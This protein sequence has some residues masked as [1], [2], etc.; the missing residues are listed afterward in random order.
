MIINIIR[1]SRCEEFSFMVGQESGACGA[2]A[3]F[4]V[5]G[6]VTLL[7]RVSPALQPNSGNCGCG[8][9]GYALAENVKC[10]G[11][12]ASIKKAVFLGALC[13]LARA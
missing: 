1:M 6:G 3:G 2:A 13:V 7:V 11:V 8:K 9:K 5:T 12:G 10:A 4:S